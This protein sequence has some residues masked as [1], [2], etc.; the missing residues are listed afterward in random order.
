A[1]VNRNPPHVTYVLNPAINQPEYGLNAD[2]AYWVSG[3][4]LRAQ[5]R[6]NP[7][8]TAS[9]DTVNLGQID[10]FSHGFGVA[11]A[12][13]LPTQYT[14]CVITGGTTVPASPCFA[15]SKDWGE[16]SFQPVADR[17]DITV[18][19]IGAMTIHVDRA[20]VTCNAALNVQTDGPL[21]VTLKGSICE[22]QVS[23]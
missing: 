16:P 13:A 19:N 1:R 9:L 6:D 8:N 20:H 4:Q 5:T 3:L 7:P 15:Q 2:H 10:V 17:L 14:P 12:P 11:D 21:T 22:R 23:F 18:T